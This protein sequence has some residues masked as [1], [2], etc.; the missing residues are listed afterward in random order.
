MG[1]GGYMEEHSQHRPDQWKR[2]WHFLDGGG[3]KI[4]E[5]TEPESQVNIYVDHV[6]IAGLVLLVAGIYFHP[7]RTT[8]RIEIIINF[9]TTS[10]SCVAVLRKFVE[11]HGDLL[12]AMI[13][14]CLPWLFSWS[15]VFCKRPSST[16]R[17][18]LAEQRIYDNW[19]D[20]WIRSPWHSSSTLL[21]LIG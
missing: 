17:R 4:A 13:S 11:S 7:P 3:D 5:V 20:G 15:K 9:H 18:R 14:N 12:K 8:P 6:V 10:C 19:T 2:R 21:C 1:I 16:G